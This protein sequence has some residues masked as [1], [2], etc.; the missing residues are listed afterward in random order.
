M[1]YWLLLLLGLTGC[2]QVPPPDPMPQYAVIGVLDPENE[3]LAVFI[4]RVFGYNEA[5]PIDSGKFVSDARVEIRSAQATRELKLNQ[6]TK[7]YEAVNQG[8]IQPGERYELWI[9]IGLDELRA[10]T[11]V[12]EAVSV[13]LASKSVANQQVEVQLAWP[14]SSKGQANYQLSAQVDFGQP[15]FPFF[16]WGDE[17][18]GTTIQEKGRV[19]TQEV[20]SPVGYFSFSA[21]E[22]SAT[23]SVQ[24]ESMDAVWFDYNEISKKLINR[25][26]ELRRFE[27][28][29]FLPSNITGG[30]GV[31]GSKTSTLLE[32]PFTL[33]TN[34]P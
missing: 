10:E 25:S 6:V 17:L 27:G 20:F 22:K 26:P 13:R 31:F 8:F 14:F 11:R 23:L 12:P 24:V 32:I 5:I 9:R 1:R 19:R 16:Y 34:S 7:E 21:R 30:L 18:F 28:P 2:I 29:L 3:K 4:S 15:S 33:N